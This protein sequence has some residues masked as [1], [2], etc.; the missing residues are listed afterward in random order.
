MLTVNLDV[1]ETQ[2]M[3]LVLRLRTSECEVGLLRVKDSIGALLVQLENSYPRTGSLRAQAE[4]EQAW[5]RMPQ[6][7]CLK[8]VE[9]SQALLDVRDHLLDALKE[10]K[11]ETYSSHREEGGIY[12]LLPRYQGGTMH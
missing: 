10:L 7:G 3:T 4:V 1:I 12:G 9:V 6:E 5:R 11:P 2:L 8:T